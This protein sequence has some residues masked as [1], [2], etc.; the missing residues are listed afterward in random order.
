MTQDIYVLDASG[1]LFRAYFAIRGM[2]NPQGEPT[3]A[4]YG[5]IRS[6]QK[7]IKDFSP[8][9]L[10][11]VFDG[12]DN[13]K[14]RSEIYS[15]YKANRDKAPED[16]IKQINWAKELCVCLG[17]PHVISSG[18][19]AD[20]VMGS[21]AR[22]MD[23]DL[24]YKVY[25]CS[26]DK[27]LTQ[28]VNP[29][30]FILNTH[31]DN[32]L[33]DAEKVEELY[34]VKPEQIVDWLAIT[35]DA[36][37]NVPGLA[38][39]GPK[40]ASSLLQKFGTLEAILNEPENVPGKKKQETIREKA[41][42][43][44]LSKKLVKIDEQIEIPKEFSF[45]EIQEPKLEDLRSFYE[46]MGFNSLLKDLEQNDEKDSVDEDVDYHCIDDESSLKE[47][48]ET[49]SKEKNLC[50]DTE[51][52]S[53]NVFEAEL[54]GIGLAKRSHEAFYIPMNGKLGREK[55]LSLLKAF[56]DS[57]T[58]SFYGHNIKYDSHI[59]REA[60]VPIRHICFD[61]LIASYLLHS[62]SQ[63]HS[64]D[65]L[66]MQ[67]FSKKKVATEELIGKGK[68]AITMNEVPIEKVSEYCC[69]D[70]DY[71]L[72]LKEVL[73]P[74]LTERGLDSLF[75]DVELPLVNVLRDMELRGIY[76]NSE[77]L[78]KLSVVLK[79]QSETAADDIF[80]LAGEVFNIN[81]PKQVAEQ[82]Y[83]KMGIYPPKKT[84]TGFSTNASVLEGLALRYPIAG[85][86]LEYRGIQKLRTTY[87][88]ALPELVNSH[89]QRIH[90][91]FKQSGT[92]TGRLS[93]Q[94]PNLQNIPVRTAMGK[95]VRAAF[96]PQKEGW[97]FLSGDYSQIELRLLAHFS[98][99]PNL[100][101]AFQKGLD[102]HA[103]TAAEIFG[104]HIDLLVPEQRYQA[105]AVNFGVIYGQKA[106]GLS[107]ELGITQK[108][109]KN[110]IEQ[111]FERYPKIKTFI[112]NAKERAHQDGKAVTLIGRERAI[113]EIHSRNAI[114][115]K[116]AERLAV[117]TPLQGTAADLIKMAM[118]RVEERIQK[119]KLRA[120][121]ILQIHDELLFESPN[122]DLQALEK[123][124]KEEMEGVMQIHVPLVVDI[125]IGSNWKECG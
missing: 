101:D 67:Y 92:A 50:I 99:D 58:C 56:L 4:L 15:D 55:A 108:A 30:V 9:H 105:K 76:L 89:T 77:H 61:T 117:N 125:G 12:P 51:T 66:C 96:K 5:F 80:E 24:G 27:D 23:K 2:S 110:F 53:L 97:S 114:Q 111:Y 7:L 62:E 83:E 65:R 71:T 70:V 20:D 73:E 25:L 17:I 93:C 26:S 13:K 47:L 115:R 59:L 3:N 88:D 40:T 68:N 69:E 46:T 36:S 72:R 43:A 21:I 112:E 123:L 38:G 10:V 79:E 63:Q 107:Q 121:M 1:Y 95:E 11:A 120:M 18:V 6:I 85:K 74:Q 42:I 118:L 82:L 75:Y 31:K 119:E 100:I 8:K 57:G 122:E 28:L 16:L 94:D 22:Q 45:Y 109:A 60:G 78:A 49:L 34:G 102:I 86:I 116:A 33:I 29:N 87:V 91:T 98:E 14:S 124:V 52:T 104:V 84:S 106:Y 41:D 39:F 64:L 113:P 44:R 103:A 81:S 35:G 19:E 48:L 90:C 37:D 54:V 32:L